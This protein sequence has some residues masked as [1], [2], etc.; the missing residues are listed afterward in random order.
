MNLSVAGHHVE[1]TPPIRQYL[2][3]KLDRVLRHFDDVTTVN[4]VLSVEKL[5]QK[6]AAT[7][8]VRGRDLH[9][10]AVDQDLYASIDA[11]A[12]KL[13]REVIRHKEKHQNHH[14]AGIKRQPLAD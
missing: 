2:E 1:V 3:E 14:G 4:V 5:Q 13:D 10:E 11:L 9:A 6:A 7:L 8:H 12:D